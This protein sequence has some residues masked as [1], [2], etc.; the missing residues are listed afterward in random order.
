MTDK[1]KQFEFDGELQI[2]DKE[3]STAP[4]QTSTDIPSD[5]PAEEPYT[6]PERRREHRRKGGDRRSEVRFE[7]GKDDRRSGGDR[8][9]GTWNG[10]YK[11]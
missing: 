6:G 10:K 5:K 11:V 8:R 4:E 9:K 3:E 1:Y 7:P 2:V